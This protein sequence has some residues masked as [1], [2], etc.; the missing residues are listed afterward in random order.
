MRVFFCQHDQVSLLF[1]YLYFESECQKE[2]PQAVC[3]QFSLICVRL[4]DCT[5]AAHLPSK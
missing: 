2:I 4:A 5:C 1:Q 3:F